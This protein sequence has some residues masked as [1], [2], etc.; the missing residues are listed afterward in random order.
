MDDQNL[1]LNLKRLR[2][3]KGLSQHALAE[4]V[5]L[6]RSAYRNLEA[7]A[8]EFRVADLRALA[9]ALE[10]PLHRLLEPVVE[11]RQ[12]RF[13]SSKK[14]K[15]R[16]YIL[17]KVG[18][19][20]EDYNQLETICEARRPYALGGT[21]HGLLA[22]ERLPVELAH[23]VRER[24]GLTASEP[25]R[26]ICGLL[27]SAGIKVG[28]MPVATDGFLGL[29]VAP[30][31]GGPAVVINTHHRISVERWIFSA[32]HELGHLL[33]H[34]DEYS[35]EDQ[36]EDQGREREADGFAAEFLMPT[37]VFWR[38]WEETYGLGFV[39]RVTKVKRIFRVSYRTVLH[40]LEPTYTGWG[41]IWQRFQA[42]Y[43]KGRGHTLTRNDEPDALSGREPD[44]LSAGDFREDRLAYLVRKAVE[45]EEISLG[46][47]AEVLELS[48]S[49]MRDL[50]SSWVG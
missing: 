28:P 17:A 31:D 26:D 43:K 8:A 13:R 32:A 9:V 29:S 47:A 25:I 35:V 37:A 10:V 11:V 50:V 49:E 12:V 18:R 4:S 19:W 38:G 44:R 6:S 36:A 1:S 3:V 34:L 16:A 30:T 21:A 15:T 42:D 20:L 14:L 23:R 48:L 39:E 22:D 33:L 7:G 40:R 46:R 5:G 27:D 41:T 24:L 2:A 45:A